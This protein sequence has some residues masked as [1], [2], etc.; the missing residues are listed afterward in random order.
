MRS[1]DVVSVASV[2]AARDVSVNMRAAR[3]GVLLGLEHQS[4]AALADNKAVAR[5]VKRAARGRGVVVAA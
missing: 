5:Y 2:A 3:L 4:S 1:G